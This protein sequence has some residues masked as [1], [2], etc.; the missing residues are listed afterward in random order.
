[1][2]GRTKTYVL[3][4]VVAIIWGVVGYNIYSSLY[5]DNPIAVSTSDNSNELFKEKKV[6]LQNSF[7]IHKHVRDPFLGTIKK[8]KPIKKPAPTRRTVKP[9]EP[10]AKVEYAGMV[11][12]GNKKQESIFF[13]NINGTSNLM[14]IHDKVS[15]IK[16]IRG[17]ESEITIEGNGKRKTIKK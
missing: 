15:G 9:A 14:H 3:L 6:K 1:M 16:L 7:A 8:E 17:D 10:E 5:S 2:K 11:K 12:T 4:T 13:V